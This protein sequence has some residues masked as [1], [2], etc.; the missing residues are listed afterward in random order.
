MDKDYI[1][2]CKEAEEIQ[3]LKLDKVEKDIEYYLFK[4]G[5]IYSGH[6]SISGGFI[7]RVR[8]MERLEH[9]HKTNHSIRSIWLPTFDQL[10]KI[11]DPEDEFFTILHFSNFFQDKMSLNHGYGL[12]F[13]SKEMIALA[14]IMERKFNVRSGWSRNCEGKLEGGWIR[15]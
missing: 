14:F 9:I 6:G 3:L 15:D 8:G 2:L 11:F 1:K 4:P 10:L 12:V 7:Y 13:H 5:D